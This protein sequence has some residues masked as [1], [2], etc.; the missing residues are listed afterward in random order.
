MTRTMWQLAAFW[1]AGPRR[2]GRRRAD[3]R[4]RRPRPW[5]RREVRPARSPD[6]GTA[7]T[8]TR[9]AEE[10]RRR[11]RST[12]SSFWRHRARRTPWRRRRRPTVRVRLVGRLRRRHGV[13]LARR[14]Q[15]EDPSTAATSARRLRREVPESV[16]S[17]HLETVTGGSSRRRHGRRRRRRLSALRR[18]AVRGSR[19]PGGRPLPRRHGHGSL[20]ARRTAPR[21][22]RARP[23]TFRSTS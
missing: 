3:R 17:R 16:R 12:G 1:I 15:V 8:P 7:R 2:E 20:P 18:T 4:L 23:G 22:R 11:S 6:T 5:R 14:R 13:R 10:A 19:D 21:T 9:P